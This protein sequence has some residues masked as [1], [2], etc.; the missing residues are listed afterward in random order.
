MWGI[1]VN[2]AIHP[3]TSNG[4]HYILVAI[5]YFT[6]WVE[7]VS[8]KTVTAMAMEKFIR[9]NIIT[10]YGVPHAIISDNG[11]NYIALRIEDYLQ[12]FKIR[13]HQSSPYQL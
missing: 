12:S 11:K 9:N 6:K 10:R 5:D 13:H 7:A 3:T 2:E 8:Y 4:H 1:D